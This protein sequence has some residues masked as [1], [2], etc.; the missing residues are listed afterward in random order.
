MKLSNSIREALL[1]DLMRHGY[2][3]ETNALYAEWAALSEAV[4]QDLYSAENHATIAGLPD[5]WLP[6]VS[7]IDV[8]FFGQRETLAFNGRFDRR[9]LANLLPT[10]GE[11]QTRRILSQ[12]TRR[13]GSIVVYSSDHPL[14]V[15]RDALRGKTQ[16]FIDRVAKGRA[17][18]WVALC[19]VT[20]VKR[21]VEVWPEVKPFAAKYMTEKPQLPAVPV[22]KLNEMLGLPVEG[23]QA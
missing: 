15:R 13:S 2:S 14:S 11:A 12:D 10:P 21:L 23:D 17:Q 9:Q 18:A 7:S 22:A 1:S 5:G 16:D 20:T 3:A 6:T 19:G 4:Y 8:A